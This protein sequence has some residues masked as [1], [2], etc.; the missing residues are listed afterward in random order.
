MGLQLRDW[1]AIAQFLFMLL[2]FAGMFYRMKYQ[3]ENNCKEIAETKKLVNDQKKTVDQ[4][5]VSLEVRLNQRVSESES[6]TREQMGRL[7]GTIMSLA[8]DLKPIREANFHLELKSANEGIAEL[9][10]LLRSC[11]WQQT[12]PSEY[13]KHSDIAGFP[14]RD[15][16]LTM[17]KAAK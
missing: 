14:T 12:R 10:E 4:S 16:V 5:L 17:I 15:E 2:G 6:R 3:T 13:L 11:P 9:K 1:I 8:S 7:E